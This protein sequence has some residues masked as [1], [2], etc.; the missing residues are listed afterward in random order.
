MDLTEE[1]LQHDALAETVVRRSGRSLADLAAQVRDSLIAKI[2]RGSGKFRNTTF[3]HTEPHH[4]DIM[5][6]YLP[7][8]IRNTREASNT[9]HFVCGTSGF[10]SVSNGFMLWQLERVKRFVKTDTFKQLVKVNYFDPG[11]EPQRRIDVWTFLDGCAAGDEETKSEGAARRFI[12]SLVE[13]FKDEVAVEPK[14]L[15]SRV[16]MLK[17]YFERQYAGQKDNGDVQL[18]KGMCREFEAE[19][20][21]GYLGWNI[22]SIK[23]LRLGFYTADIFAPEPTM[24]RDAAPI[25]SLM[26]RV[27]PEVVTVALDPEASGPDTH[28]KVLQAVTAALEQYVKEKGPGSTNMKVWGYRNVWFRFQPFEATTIFPVSLMTIATLDH[29]FLSSFES[30]KTAEFPAHELEGPFCD[31][32][33]KV[34]VEQYKMIKT[35]LGAEWFN[36]N[37]SALIRGTRGLVFLKEMDLA[38][39]TQ[40]SRGLR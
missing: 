2:E 16:R 4:N 37:P 17:D 29:M 27:K 7:G 8:V 11:E 12:R 39:L 40:Y 24:A 32:S 26:R 23:H 34:Q 33:R 9:H 25:V 35:C 5:L 10:N 3:L 15:L 13:V 1:D 30:Q 19:V 38:E 31:M 20:V 36:E 28:Y 18:L 14:A 22:P 21:W 6:G